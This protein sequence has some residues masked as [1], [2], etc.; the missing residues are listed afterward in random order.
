MAVRCYCRCAMGIVFGLNTRQGLTKTKTAIRCTTPRTPIYLA[1][2]PIHKQVLCITELAIA[3][4]HLC[5]A[6]IHARHLPSIPDNV[7]GAITRPM[8]V[9]VCNP[10]VPYTTVTMYGIPYWCPLRGILVLKPTVAPSTIP[11]WRFGRIHRVPK[12]NY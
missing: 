3:R 10:V 5:R 7:Y 8:P 6:T 9:R 1:M 12:H 2:A 4:G 11:A